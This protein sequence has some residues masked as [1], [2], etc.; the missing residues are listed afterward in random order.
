LLDA[1]LTLSPDRMLGPAERQ[2]LYRGR[3][4]SV[5]T[6]LGELDVVQ[7]LP[8]IP[9]FQHLSE[10]AGSVKPFGST[11]RVASRADLIDMKRARGEAIDVADLEQLERED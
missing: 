8:G 11:L 7:R 1:R 2:A 4:L 3:N 6:R 5:T 9:G 10:N